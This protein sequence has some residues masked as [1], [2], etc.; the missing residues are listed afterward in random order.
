VIFLPKK[1][2]K[3]SFIIYA[4]LLIIIVSFVATLIT[5]PRQIT[6]LAGEDYI[7]S[8]KSPFFLQA[9][10]KNQILKVSD[11]ANKVINAFGRPYTLLATEEGQAELDLRMFGII[12]I[13]TVQV[14]SIVSQQVIACG[15]PI[16][17]KLKTNGIVIINISGVVLDD[18]TRISPAE[19]AGLLAGDILIK[20]GG[21]NLGNIRDLI[22]VV[23]KSAGKPVNISYKRDNVQ[24]N[25]AITPIKSGEDKQYRIG[26]WVRDSSAG[27]GTLTFVD[28]LNKTYGALGHGINDIDTGAL[29]Q[30]GSGQLMKSNIEGIKKGTK[31]SPGELE[32]EF[33]S[34]PQIIGDIEI[35]C[36]FGVFG[37][38]NI[39]LKKDKFG[40]AIPIG[41][42]STVHAGKATILACIRDNKV[43]EYD[44]EIQRI[45]KTDLSSTK[46]MVIRITDERLLDSTGG[47]V[48]G[49]SGS[50]ILQD[51]RLIGA[52]THV[53]INDPVRGYGVFIESMLDKSNMLG[54]QSSFSQAAGQ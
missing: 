16:G 54:K 41:S 28:S 21:K 7:W 9:R 5:L 25:T 40:R 34:N 17:I 45:A 52:V 14:R 6:L 35:N 4:L 44:I 31:G 22:D 33:L 29:L 26:I 27:I 53:F 49:M 3:T 11:S 51:G 36:E 39:D 32:G 42:H 38:L 46:N 12:P 43:E 37:K 15:T 10:S 8:F 20:A 48:Q 19:T 30:V 47:I 18:G 13:K 24:Y 50:P 23:E 1:T 2:L